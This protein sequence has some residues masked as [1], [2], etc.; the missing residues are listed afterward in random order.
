[1]KKRIIVIVAI[2]LIAVTVSI[3][4]T[5]NPITAYCIG[6]TVEKEQDEIVYGFIVARQNEEG[7]PV[8][9]EV[10]KQTGDF[11]YVI[12]ALKRSDIL[13]FYPTV[14]SIYISDEIEK[15]EIQNMISI[16]FQMHSF[17]TDIVVIK[18][19]SPQK[20]IL[21][22]DI[23]SGIQ[24]ALFIPKLIKNQKCKINLLQYK[25]GI[26]IP[27]ITFDSGQFIINNND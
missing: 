7:E 14:K 1:M 20:L 15:D 6:L 17:P 27:F 26:Q 8:E 21:E 25:N 10:V 3:F 5:R 4:E 16:L 13:L 23:A 24:G 9:I 12:E 2:I 22:K 19:S 11:N 18:C